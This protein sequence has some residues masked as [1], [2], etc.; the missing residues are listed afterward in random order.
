MSG[1]EGL[2]LLFRP[3]SFEFLVWGFDGLRGDMKLPQ[4][5][6]VS[7]VPVQHKGIQPSDVLEVRVG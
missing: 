5:S 1:A 7:L 2:R 4:G 3:L 6:M